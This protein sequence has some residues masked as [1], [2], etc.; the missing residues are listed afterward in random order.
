MYYDL[1]IPNVTLLDLTHLLN[2]LNR[3]TYTAVAIDH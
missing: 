2:A 3:N 1:S